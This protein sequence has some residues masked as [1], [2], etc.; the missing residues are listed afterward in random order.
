MYDKIKELEQRLIEANNAYRDGNPIMTDAQFDAMEE[1]LRILDSNNN[2]FKRGVN[3]IAPKKRKVRLPYPM[4][5][6]NKHKTIDALLSWASNYPDATFIITPKFDG[7]SVGI[8]GNTAWTRGDGTIG[9]DCTKQLMYVAKP[10][11]SEKDVIRGEIIFTNNNWLK[12]KNINNEAVCSRNSAT[13]LINGDFDTNRLHEYGLLSIMPYEII[14]S[15]LS[16]E[17]QLRLLQTDLYVKVYG[18]K[19]LTDDFL[20]NLFVKWKNKYPIDGLVIDVNEPQYRTGTEANGNP[21]YSVAYKS[22]NF[23][24]TGTGIIKEIE[25]NINRYGIATPV[26]ILEEPIFLSGASISRVN[27]I[28]MSYVKSW[29]IVPGE[30]V[31]IVRSGEVIPKIIGVGNVIIPFR[32]TYT[33]VGDYLIDYN[34]NSIK[35]MFEM[36]QTNVVLPENLK[37]CPHCGTVLKELTN[38]NDDWCEMYCPNIECYG[39]QIET[40]IKFFTI[41]QI[42]G[43]G[44]KKIAQLADEFIDSK[45]PIFFNILNADI[46]F[47]LGFEG[48]AE[49]SA[50]TFINECNKIKTQLPFA[51]FLHATG[52]FGELG[53]KTLQK[54]LDADGWEMEIDDLVKIDGIQ[55]KTATYFHKGKNIFNN[56]K[57]IIENIFKFAYIKTSDIKKEGILSGMNVC[58]TGFRDKMLSSQITENGGNV[59]DSFTKNV[60]CLITKDKNSNSS[61]I[62]KAHKLGI[63]VVEIDEFKAKYLNYGN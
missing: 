31:Q 17:A 3:D 36:E 40:A 38:E 26:A 41:A 59:L 13:G 5:S 4:M 11:L 35:R 22:P 18:I 42:D 1:E 56:Y 21:S 25:L 23:S 15:N 24:E 6:L 12:F 10:Q 51:R 2:W 57:D 27:A 14:N 37:V 16:K 30:K 19:H 55:T 62:T 7:L 50:I 29:G 49:T 28:N 63:E 20:L 60:N 43:F 45:T 47:L 34:E 33:N 61:K 48:W 46:N 54:I 32:E 39:R 44:E 9:Q 8:E 53:E 58:M 52:W